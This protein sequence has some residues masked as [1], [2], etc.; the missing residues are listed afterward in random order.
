MR[1]GP[2]AEVRTR[3]WPFEPGKTG[4]S[5]MCARFTRDAQSRRIGSSFGSTS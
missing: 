5:R 2:A 3:P 1:I 4:A